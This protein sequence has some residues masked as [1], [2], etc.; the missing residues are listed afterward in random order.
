MWIPFLD[1]TLNLANSLRSLSSSKL[2]GIAKAAY[3]SPDFGVAKR[4]LPYAVE[5]L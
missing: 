5:C 2:L 1:A 4:P 3:L